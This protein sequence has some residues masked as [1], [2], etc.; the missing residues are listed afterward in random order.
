M[1]KATA[2]LLAL[3]AALRPALAGLASDAGYPV[4]DARR[5]AQR[6]LDD[7]LLLE[8]LDRQSS[9]GDEHADANDGGPPAPGNSS[10][11]H[12]PEPAVDAASGSADSSAEGKPAADTTPATPAAE[13]TASD[14]PD[15]N[16]LYDGSDLVDWIRGAPGGYVHPNARIGLDPSGKYRGVFVKTVEE[17]GTGEGIPE[18]EMLCS[19][20]WYV[21][22][23]S[24]MKGT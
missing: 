8:D 11:G 16:L 4:G 17:G 23:P 12:A 10:A 3:S 24:L 7:L 18:G 14:P 20:P 5:L 2:T 22:W 19:I 13:G 9:D 6:A 15:A 21:F 1:M